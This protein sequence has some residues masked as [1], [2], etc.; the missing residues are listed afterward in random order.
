[1]VCCGSCYLKGTSYIFQVNEPMNEDGNL[2][3]NFDIDASRYKVGM[4]QAHLLDPFQCYL[5]VFCALYHR[6]TRRV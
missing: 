1:M 4:D 6:N 2:L 5:C 3:Y